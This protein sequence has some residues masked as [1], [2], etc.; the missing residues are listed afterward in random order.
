MERPPVLKVDT[1]ARHPVW[2]PGQTYN[3][4]TVGKLVQ[5]GSHLARLDSLEAL[6]VIEQIADSQLFHDAVAAALEDYQ[7]VHVNSEDG[8]VFFPYAFQIKEGDVITDEN[9]EPHKVTTIYRNGGGGLYWNPYYRRACGQI[10]QL[11]PLPRWDAVL[12]LPSASKMLFTA[13]FPSEPVVQYLQRQQLEHHQ[14]FAVRITK[15]EPFA[16][17]NGIQER[18]GIRRQTGIRDPH[19]PHVQYEMR[20]FRDLTTYEF[21]VF[22]S[23]PWVVDQLLRYLGAVLW[24]YEPSFRQLGISEMFP[25]GRASDELIT[26]GADNWP[27]DSDLHIRR[28]YWSVQTS[29][30]LLTGQRVI[31]RLKITISANP[32]RGTN[33]TDEQGQFM[34]NK[35]QV[36]HQTDIYPDGAAPR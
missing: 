24:S 33:A 22:A 5:R 28:T 21:S 23:L 36:F 34:E 8:R 13:A 19:N 15:S 10:V 20:V 18:F 16:G 2:V 31:D 3:A 1:E 30:V 26:R 7:A 6:P 14:G 35:P 9:G 29:E 11:T 32:W 4:A 12:R 25:I 17:D 27:I